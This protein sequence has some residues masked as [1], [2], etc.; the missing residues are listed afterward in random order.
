MKL[1]RYVLKMF[2]VCEDRTQCQ[3]IVTGIAVSVVA[4]I[5]LSFVASLLFFHHWSVTTMECLLLVFIGLE[6]KMYWFLKKNSVK[7]LRM[8][9]HIE[10]MYN[11]NHLHHHH[12]SKLNV[13]TL[14]FLTCSIS[15]ASIHLYIYISTQ[16]NLIKNKFS[17]RTNL[18]LFY[19]NIIIINFFART[20]LMISLFFCFQ[21]RSL[22]YNLYIEKYRNGSLHLFIKEDIEKFHNFYISNKF[23]FISYI[24][25]LEKLNTMCIVCYNLYLIF[26]I[27]TIYDFNLNK[28]EIVLI[29]ISIIIL[30]SYYIMNYFIMKRKRRIT[31][32]ISTC[33]DSMRL[34]IENST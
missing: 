18:P 20:L 8:Y 9:D 33:I 6:I 3:I 23:S 34:F 12:E 15:F 5:Y 16:N 13:S 22:F 29:T 19:V 14:Y 27:L 25:P 1:L 24:E 21:M 31:R 10:Q 7:L 17:V 4:L 26:V 11:H 28:I 32:F 30:N 2:G